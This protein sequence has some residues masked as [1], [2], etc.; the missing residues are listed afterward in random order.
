MVIPYVRIITGGWAAGTAILNAHARL[1]QALGQYRSA[2]GSEQ[3]LD[4]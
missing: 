4:F 1:E 2:A 3:F